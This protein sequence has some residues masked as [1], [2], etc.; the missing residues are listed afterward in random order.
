LQE[1]CGH[2]MLWVSQNCC[3]PAVDKIIPCNN[4]C[5]T[6]P[7]E[8][9]TLSLAQNKGWDLFGGFKSYKFPNVTNDSFLRLKILCITTIRRLARFF[10]RIHTW[11]YFVVVLLRDCI[12]RLIDWCLM[13]T[14]AV[15]QL[16][17][18][19]VLEGVSVTVTCGR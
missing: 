13:P 8:I 1:F 11:L 4:F 6:N 15:F 2:I 18:G 14:L 10:L 17:S 16:Y 5:L 7:S 9:L 12:G 3:C 19:G